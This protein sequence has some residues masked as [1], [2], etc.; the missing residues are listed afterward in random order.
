M[1]WFF[2]FGDGVVMLRARAEGAVGTIGDASG[3]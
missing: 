2:T 3:R 1:R